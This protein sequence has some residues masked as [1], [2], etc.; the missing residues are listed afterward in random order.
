L[1]WDA[2]PRGSFS[3]EC[4]INDIY[5]SDGLRLAAAKK[6][7]EIPSVLAKAG[8]VSGCP[9]LHSGGWQLGLAQLLIKQKRF[10]PDVKTYLE[11]G[12]AFGYSKA[13]VAPLLASIAKVTQASAKKL[14]KPNSRRQK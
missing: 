9:H 12:A 4:F 1:K 7:S 5:T 11:R 3:C 13:K 10:L 8:A 2:L 14:R 6:W